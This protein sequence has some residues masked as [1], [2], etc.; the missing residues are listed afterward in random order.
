MIMDEE[1]GKGRKNRATASD[2]QNQPLVATVV[3]ANLIG[4]DLTE[5][6]TTVLP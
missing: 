3:E 1:E 6:A 2:S 4:N 5:A